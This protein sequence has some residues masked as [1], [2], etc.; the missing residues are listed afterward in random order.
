MKFCFPV[1]GGFFGLLLRP[2]AAASLVFCGREFDFTAFG[3]RVAARLF[4]RRSPGSKTPTPEAG[5][6]SGR[7]ARSLMADNL[8]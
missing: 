6:G 8:M 5:S 7:S 4:S 1:L 2:L 3:A